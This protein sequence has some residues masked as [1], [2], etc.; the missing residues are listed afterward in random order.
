MKRKLVIAAA[1]LLIVIVGLAVH[2]YNSIDAIVESA[3]EKHG[4]RVLGTEVS[5]GSVD[6]S[7]KS[8]RG[9]I[10]DVSVENPDGFSSGEMFKLEEITVD[11]DV[12]SLTRDPITID[13]VTISAPEVR[14]EMNEKG[15]T[16]VG[17]LKS[18]ADEYQSAA[19]SPERKQ[20]GGFEKRF[21]ITKFVFEKG[22]VDLDAAAMGVEAVDLELPPVRLS[23]VGGP[24]GDTPDGIGK[25]V[26][27]AFLGAV[28]SVVTNEAK[29][30]A[31]DKAKEKITDA[32]KEAVE[33][34]FKK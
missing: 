18:N 1:G 4:S 32:A 19:P 16:N 30:R 14:V 5:V 13:E 33:D 15:Q 8:G 9:T 20:D 11:I 12:K 27:R 2:F 31:T 24:N 26:T 6:I 28:T 21:V 3:I 10:R 17:V 25:T 7:L 23:N 22:V 34:I 29:K